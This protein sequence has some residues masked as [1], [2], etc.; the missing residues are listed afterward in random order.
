MRKR[1]KNKVMLNAWVDDR[2]MAALDQFLKGYPQMNRSKVLVQA[3]V[4]FLSEHGIPVPPEVLIDFRPKK[5]LRPDARFW[6]DKATEASD[7]LGH[8]K[9]PLPIK[10]DAI[11][12]NWIVTLFGKPWMASNPSQREAIRDFALVVKKFVELGREMERQPVSNEDAELSPQ[13]Q[14]KKRKPKKVPGRAL[15][16]KTG[17]S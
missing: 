5:P 4:T 12:D 14:N 6:E 9:Q 10:S 15:Q 16:M 8:I 13:P 7:Y 3:L 11:S 17:K 2:L 1:A